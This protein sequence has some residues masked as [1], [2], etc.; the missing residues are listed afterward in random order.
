LR[1]PDIHGSQTDLPII[2]GCSAEKVEAV[3]AYL[4]AHFPAY[5]LRHF[6]AS[7]RV[8]EHGRPIARD[9][10]HVVGVLH[11][12]VLSYYAVLLNEFQEYSVAEIAAR[13][14]RWNLADVLRANRVAITSKVGVTALF[15]SER[16][17]EKSDPCR[18]M[19]AISIR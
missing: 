2:C 12:G 6:H 3:D 10:H 18:P 15:D 11:R 9:D 7:R 5:E 8:V 19:R 16:P 17:R 13:L 4:H 1:A 14:R